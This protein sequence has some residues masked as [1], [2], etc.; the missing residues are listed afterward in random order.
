MTT[1]TE[2]FVPRLTPETVSVFLAEDSPGKRDVVIAG[3][4][5][6]GLD[7]SVTIATSWGEAQD[8]IEAQQPGALEANVFILDGNLT[9]GQSN[10]WE[11]SRLA[12]S[13]RNKFYKPF[14]DLTERALTDMRA[15][16]VSLTEAIR[17]TDSMSILRGVATRQMQSEALLV[18]IS[19]NYDGALPEGIAQV[20]IV[21]YRSAGNVV[22]DRVIPKKLRLQLARQTARMQNE[23][24]RVTGALV[25]DIEAE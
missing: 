12:M 14:Q 16:G 2:F 9:L 7:H 24:R 20:P 18:G 8:F 10:T 21:D 3:L 11:G 1:S 4:G 25:K 15:Q 6:W 17:A 5:K 19:P 22:Y 23:S 13:L